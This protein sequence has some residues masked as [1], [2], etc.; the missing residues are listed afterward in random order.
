MTRP[1]GLPMRWEC[2]AEWMVPPG[3]CDAHGDG[4]RGAEQHTRDTGHP[5]LTRWADGT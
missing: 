2:R 5:T 1:A 4:D 3:A